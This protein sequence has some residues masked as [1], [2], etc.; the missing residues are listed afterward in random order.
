MTKKHAIIDGNEAVA[1]V[2]Y[3]TNE[4]IAIYPITPAS[5]M[6]ELADAWA[7][8]GKQNIWGNV[9]S[10]IEMQSEGGAAGAVHGALQ[11]GS[12]TT[13]FTASQGLLLM[14][15]NMYKIAGELTSTVFHIAA[16]SIAAQ[17][18][19]IFGDHSDVMAARQ[20]GFALLASNSVQEAMDMALI[21]QAASLES[22]IPF[23]HFFDGFRTSHEINQ[24]EMLSDKQIS[25]MIKDD[26]VHSHRRRA[27]SPD[28]PVVRGTAQNPDVYFQARE[29]VNP[30][31]Q[32]CPDI[33]QAIMDK[34]GKI[35]GRKYKLFDYIG[36]PDAERIIVA[37][38]S[39]LGAIEETVNDLVA[40]GEKV[41]AIK[42]RLFR[43]FSTA[44]LLAALP[45]SVQSIGV[46]DRTKEPGSIGEP[47]YM[48]IQTALREGID[49]GLWAK[50]SQPKIVGGRYG[51]S[52]KEFTPAMILRIYDELKEENPKNHFTIGIEDDVSLKSLNYVKGYSAEAP[53]TFKAVFYGLGSDGTVGANK[54]TIKI[55]GQQTEKSVQ[56]YFVYDSKKAGSVTVSHLRFGDQKIRSTYLIDR[57]N[58][59]ACHQFNFLQKF[60]L[61]KKADQG[62]TFLLNSPYSADIVWDYLP[63]IVQKHI[64]DKELRFF[65]T[66]AYK[67]ASRV[68]LGGHINTI[69]Q[70]A[71]FGISDV[72]PKAKAIKE[73]KKAIR[74]NYGKLGKKILAQNNEAVDLADSSVEE[75]TVPSATLGNIHLNEPV[76]ESAPQF[77]RDVLGRIILRE[78]DDLPVSV[79]PV[80]G[81]YPAGTTQWEKRRLSD[82]VP[83]WHMDDCIQCGK[84][85][86]VCPHAVIREKIFDP[87]LLKNAPQ[88]FKSADARWREFP[89]MA[90]S[91]QVSV[92]DCTGCNLCVEACPVADKETGKK[93]PIEMVP[94]EPILA[95]EK[96]NWEY[97]LSLPE[98]DRSVIP[99]N[100]V[101]NS[102]LLQPLFEFSGACLGCGETPYLKLISQLYGE[103]TIVANATGCSSIFGGNLP[104]TPWA[105]NR[106]GRGPA[107]SNSLFEDN[108]EFG[109]GMRLSLDA[110]LESA[111]ALVGKQ[112]DKIGPKLANK[113]LKAD[114]SDEA[115]IQEQ[116]E[117]VQE[118]KKILANSKSS[119]ARNLMNLA[120]VLVKKTV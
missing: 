72:I 43:P 92:E 118:L 110:Q 39:G 82:T 12:L 86:F 16:R 74:K 45:K 106:E 90:F 60:D 95:E 52:S 32:R 114:Q 20:T 58:L 37:M 61:L 113:I 53:S 23:L 47:L 109:L 94:V 14:L 99:L 93:L 89:D 84:C 55:I 31:Y 64:I 115:G 46:M 68:G 26:L 8:E 51:L 48:D 33:V 117:R 70:T 56:A 88:G 105:V 28:H 91:L 42:V 49:E 98:M 112:K 34:F 116:R 96:V 79:F 15:P 24:V 50:G 77:V 19:S 41:G 5:S 62:A 102:Q 81:T 111:L 40:K 120:D 4:V 3:R 69:M 108:A 17:A 119:G 83:I 6:G 107:W 13:T 104:T 103:R 57:A 87:A 67:I 35:S 59:I 2:A 71:F 76:T 30:F 29:S 9:P 22:R 73:I 21:A 1:S 63:R 36:A 38:G 10:V 27:L 101:K 80:D 66:D 78:G 100:T 11:A 18:L 75:V 97:F 65:V 25:T 85:V 54:S 7:A 44:H